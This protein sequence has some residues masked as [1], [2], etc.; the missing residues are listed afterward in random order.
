M[1]VRTQYRRPFAFDLGCWP[2]QNARH[3][4]ARQTFE[5]HFLRRKPFAMHLAMNH[6]IQRRLGRHGKQAIGHRHPP[7]QLSLA[8]LP[9]FKSLGYG[10]RKMAIQILER[11]K[12]NIIRL[13]ALGKCTWHFCDDGKGANYCA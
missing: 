11:F 7:P 1:P 10:K 6:R 4:K 12:A 2:K 8:R 9:R 3:I 5:I 13:L